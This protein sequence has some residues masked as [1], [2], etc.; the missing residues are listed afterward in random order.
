[1]NTRMG[2]VAFAMAVGPAAL[3]GCQDAAQ[4]R[5][6]ADQAAAVERT[7]CTADFTEAA[8]AR[9]LDGSAV[10]RVDPI[11]IGTTSKSS[12]PRLRGAAILV[13]PVNGQTA[14]WLDRALECHG[15]QQL[16]VHAGGSDT[17]ADPFWL[18]GALVQIDVTSA[19]DGFRIEVTGDSTADAQAILA[20]A[21]AL[22]SL[23]SD[24]QAAQL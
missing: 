16:V 1:M 11:Y 6:P 13:R 23:R 4:F 19:R 24:R 9:V 10:E 2:L 3:V 15:A 17:S 14:E 12:N 7:R 20:R 18:P 8:V 21:Q 22:S 5:S